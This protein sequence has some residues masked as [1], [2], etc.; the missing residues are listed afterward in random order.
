M[1]MPSQFSFPVDHPSLEPTLGNF[2]QDFS[3]AISPRMQEPL[4]DASA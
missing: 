1:R 2:Y 4:A 3:A